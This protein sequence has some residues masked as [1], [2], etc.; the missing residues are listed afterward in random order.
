MIFVDGENFTLRGQA[1]AAQHNVE[2]ETGPY[3]MRDVFLWLR[4]IL[5]NWWSIGSLRAPALRAHYY[6]SVVGDQAKLD[7]VRE[8]LWSIGFDPKVF[9][10]DGRNDKSKGVDV[11]LT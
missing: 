9:K 7:S 8:A 6:T 11:T 10:K 1:F 3:F 2:L 5:A 4:D